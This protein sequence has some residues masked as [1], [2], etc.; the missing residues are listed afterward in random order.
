M[1][2]GPG[3]S[4]GEHLDAEFKIFYLVCLPFPLESKW[5]LRGG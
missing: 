3:Q 1:K 2:L 4:S 5:I